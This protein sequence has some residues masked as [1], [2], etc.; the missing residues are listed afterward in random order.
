MN[1]FLYIKKLI[2]SKSSDS[3]KRFLGIGLTVL[4]YFVTLRYTTVE[5]M[6]FVLGE[7]LSAILVIMG[8]STWETI[9]KQ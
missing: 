4:V 1:V 9:K 5:N 8:V 6:E 2:N 7:L 3:S